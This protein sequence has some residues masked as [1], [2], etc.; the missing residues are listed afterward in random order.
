MNYDN[1]ISVKNTTKGVEITLSGDLTLNNATIIKTELETYIN[2]KEPIMFLVKDVEAID[3][4]IFQ[5]LQSFSWTKKQRNEKVN[6]EFSLTAEQQ[7][8]IDNCGILLRN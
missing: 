6:V 3:L 8:L 2:K 5:L 1:L 4:S 7:Q